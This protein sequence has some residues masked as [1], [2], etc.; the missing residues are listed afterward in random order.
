M[1]V[2]RWRLFACFQEKDRDDQKA[3][4]LIKEISELGY[5]AKIWAPLP[6]HKK[7]GHIHVVVLCTLEEKLWLSGISPPT[8]FVEKGK[9]KLLAAPVGTSQ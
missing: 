4:D 3:A 6:H 9:P 7:T 2:R 5:R 8:N 1:A